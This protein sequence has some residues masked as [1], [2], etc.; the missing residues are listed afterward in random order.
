MQ[1]IFLKIFPYCFSD[2]ISSCITAS[3]AESLQ[4]KGVLFVL[5]HDMISKS[6]GKAL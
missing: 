2:F 6:A 5:F 3:S 4:A 1:H